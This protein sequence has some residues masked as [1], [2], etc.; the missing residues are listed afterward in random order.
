M[1][2]FFKVFCY[3][4]FVTAIKACGTLFGAFPQNPLTAEGPLSAEE[5][6][7]FKGGWESLG[8]ISAIK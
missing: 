6:F 3:T 5:E 2:P 7:D 1:L 8:I 4:S